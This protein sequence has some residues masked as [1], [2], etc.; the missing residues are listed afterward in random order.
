MS[1]TPIKRLAKPKKTPLGLVP[2]KDLIGLTR[3][4]NKLI[5]AALT[6]QSAPDAS[7]RAFMARQLV[8]C[9]L[10][11]SDPGD[12]LVWSRKSG[13]AY[14]GIQPGVDLKTK[15]SIG[16]PYGSIP[17]LLLFWM[18]TEVQLT[19]N[20]TDLT[21]VEKRTLNL[22][23]SLSEFMRRVGLNPETGRGPRGDATRLHEQIERLFS[24]RITFQENRLRGTIEVSPQSELWWDPKD[25]EKKTL[26]HSWVLLGED[27]Y[28]ALVASPVPMDMRALAALKRSPLALDLYAWVCYRAFIVISKNQ[29]P[30]PMSWQTLMKQL[31][32]DYSDHRNFRLKA[33]EAFNKIAHL[34]PGLTITVHSGGF[35][36]HAT[37]LAVL[38]SPNPQN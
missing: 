34:Y 3:A 35:T 18:T 20:R 13:N 28:Q 33:I 8:Q 9:T 22:G 4:E 2:V 11:H 37:R 16:C 15:K 17:R 36:F 19:K 1:E 14:L 5:D 32:T 23:S 27:F 7:E 31:G 21:Q 30:Q 10:P 24:S 6:I 25:P 29:P 38:S 26:W 12:V